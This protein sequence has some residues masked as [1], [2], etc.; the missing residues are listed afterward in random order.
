M[1]VCSKCHIEYDDKYSFCKKCGLAL[2]D[3]QNRQSP[4][5]SHY[6]SNDY[7]NRYLLIFGI[8]LVIVLGGVGFY[9]FH[10]T[11]RSLE[12]QVNKQK[13]VI[14]NADR[15]LESQKST[16]EE[17][18]QKIKELEEVLEDSQDGNRSIPVQDNSRLTMR[19]VPEIAYIT[20]T[21]VRFRSFP[22][23]SIIGSFDRGEEVSILEN[24]NHWYKVRRKD[25]S[26]GY[27]SAQYCKRKNG[28][29]PG[30][31]KGTEVRFRQTPNGFVIG[32]FRKGEAVTVIGKEGNWYNVRRENG[33]SG[34]VSI[35]Y[36]DIHEDYCPY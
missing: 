6:S 9:Y 3:V 8:V 19:I 7:F 16:L 25:G 33:A 4:V 11:V 26:V 32:Y 13:L 5:I 21:Y 34:Y 18:Q 27:V 30:I 1:K 2:K 24:A 31:I 36:C 17:Q 29:Y 22:N 20:G 35:D 12:S 28:K 14:N 23:G 15:N 10:S